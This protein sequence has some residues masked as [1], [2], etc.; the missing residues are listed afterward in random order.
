MNLKEK[1]VKMWTLMQEGPQIFQ[2]S[3][4]CLQILFIT[5]GTTSNFHTD[6]PK[7]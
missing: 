4:S 3:S 1:G 2:K 6:D 7:L 5:R